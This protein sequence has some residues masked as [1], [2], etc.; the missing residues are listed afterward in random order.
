MHALIMRMASQCRLGMCA[1]VPVLL[2][3]LVAHV[4]CLQDLPEQMTNHTFVFVIGSH[5]S[6]TTLLDLV[7][8]QHKDVTCLLDTHKPEN[9]GQHLHNVYASANKA[10]GMFG[11]GFRE[12]NHLTEDS[13]KLTD[14]NRQRVWASWAKYW[15]TE[16]PVL[17]E[18]S[19]P[20][21]VKTRFLQE[22]FTAERTYFVAVTRHPLACAH[23]HYMRKK[24]KRINPKPKSPLSRCGDKYVG[25]WLQIYGLLAKDAPYLKNL[26]M[27]QY[28][29]MM[30][31]AEATN[32]VVTQ[33]LKFIKVDPH[34]DLQFSNPESSPTR[35]L[36]H[37]HEMSQSPEHSEP[38]P[39]SSS[40]S[41]T[42]TAHSL[43]QGQR[44]L[45]DG[46]LARALKEFHGDKH[47]VHITLSTPHWR[48]DFVSQCD[49]D[50]SFY[51]TVK[52]RYAEE[53]KRF[54][55]SLDDLDFY[56]PPEVFKNVMINP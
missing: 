5:H 51:K 12:S 29:T 31:S 48:P 14:K 15:H 21:I 3:L 10:G 45:P 32:S 26:R 17:L 33:L 34:I 6:G 53:L 41:A 2:G 46:S 52:E 24:H 7:L 55:Y 22:L 42:T 40:T 43:S 23:F 35:E 18:K 9:E 28:E 47:H 1:M 49:L 16:K 27:I 20:H 38:H 39:A 36:D 8:C 4:S 13:E 37:L 50:G 44:A 54:G 19:P 11:Y 30:A 56:E 25:H